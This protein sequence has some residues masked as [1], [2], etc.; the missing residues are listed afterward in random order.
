MPFMF[1]GIG[2]AGY[3]TGRT[4]SKLVIN[5]ISGPK[6]WASMRICARSL[7]NVKI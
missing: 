5:L 3:D 1:P 7:I 6:G 2:L 4:K